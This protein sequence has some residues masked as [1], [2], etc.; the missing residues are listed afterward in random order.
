M[1][2]APR[3]SVPRS[4]GGVTPRSVLIGLAFVPVSVYLV[5]QWETVWTTQYPTSMGIFFNAIF[6]LFLITAFNFSLKKLLPKRA[7]SQGELLTIYTVLMMAT[8]VSGHDFSQSIFGSLGTA[9]WFATPEN[10]WE[11]LFWK[12][13]PAWLTVSDKKVL[14]GFYEG[15]STLY[16]PNHIKGWLAP[17]IWWTVFLTALSFVMLCMNSIVR[18]Q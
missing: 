8:S 11:S 10:E 3:D 13:I 6:C 16:L 1:N 14:D 18:K 4:K 9:R 7:L 15:Q 12:D 5:V 17:L 2:D